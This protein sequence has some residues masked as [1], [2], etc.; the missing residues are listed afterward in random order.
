LYACIFFVYGHMQREKK[1][2]RFGPL[3]CLKDMTIMYEK[4]QVSGL[5]ACIPGQEGTANNTPIERQE[6]DHSEE[7]EEE[8]VTPS[9]STGKYLKRKGK[10]LKKSPFKK[11]KNPM[12]R[13]M[14]R[15]VDDVISANSVTS[16]ALSGDF[17]HE[18]IRGYY[19]Q[20]TT[21]SS[22]EDVRKPKQT[23]P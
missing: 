11:G 4:S 2:C 12:V 18:S 13:V 6:K 15:M 22:Q 9:S 23:P 10:S 8:Q 20:F 16:K 17:T 21:K 5:F 19:R 3:N 1:T 14:S 7:H